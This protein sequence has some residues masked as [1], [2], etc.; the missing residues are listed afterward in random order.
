MSSSCFPSRLIEIGEE[1]IRICNHLKK[2]AG[3]FAT[4]TWCWG[5][6]APIRLCKDNLSEMADGIRFHDLPPLFQD[7]V[8]VT[9]GL[10]FR[11]LW[12]DALCICQNDELD[13]KCEVPRIPEYYASAEI[14]IVAG[15][16]D[17]HT[18]LLCPR[19]PPRFRPARLNEIGDVS[20]GWLGTDA[21]N[22]PRGLRVSSYPDAWKYES[23]HL[24]AWTMQEI[25]LARRNLVLQCDE[26][27]AQDSETMCTLL[28]SQMYMHARRRSNGKMGEED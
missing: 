13:F 25:E 5:Q 22:D 15:V 21:Y 11:Y 20:I 2:T 28:T 4:L 12:I 8:C 10:G 16:K 1:R 23:P 24:R 6:H 14:N 27:S 26:V 18:R 7:V 9:R 3:G 17:S 19:I